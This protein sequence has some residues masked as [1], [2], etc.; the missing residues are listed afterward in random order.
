[1]KKVAILS[2]SHK[3]LIC[4]E[5]RQILIDA[6]FELVC[7]DTGR[8]L[9][10]EEQKEMIQGVYG[11]I[12]GTEVYDAEMLAGL[13]EL[14]VVSRF[15][16]GT[17]NF[18]LKVM[19]EMGLEVGVIANHNAVAEFALTLM[20]SVMKN[21]PLQDKAA[22]NAS[23]NRASTREL[24][25]KTVGLLGFG[26]IGRRVAELLKGF[27]VNILAYDPY[28]N[29]QAAAERG[30]KMVSFEEVITQSDIVSLH[31]PYMESTH[32]IIDAKAIASM[33]DGA[34]LINT[35]R[36]PLVDENALAEALKAGKLTGAGVDVYETEP[37]LP[38]NPLI[39]LANTVMTPHVSALTYETNYNG[40]II[41]A[42][43]IVNV[44]NG[45]KPLYPLW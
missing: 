45:G 2:S 17:D 3:K 32:H 15:G 5:A 37:I 22:R 44:L 8:R 42:Q 41:C 25:A 35:A 12:A 21:L 9:N 7:N 18:D 14:K 31:L 24:T 28:P 4:D 33:K 30:V 19:K 13:D 40:G 6:G 38:D 10:R 36:G 26:R 16:V 20:L 27:D 11:I 39:P 23:W 34:Y 29:E 43:S 1:M